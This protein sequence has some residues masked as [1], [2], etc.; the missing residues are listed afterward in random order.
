[1]VAR[2]QYDLGVCELELGEFNEASV[3]LV[4]A[5]AGF[6]QVDRPTEVV[7]TSWSPRRLAVLAG[8]AAEGTRRLD[9]ARADALRLRMSDDAAKITLDLVQALLAAGEVKEIRRLLTQAL[10]H[11]RDAGQ[12]AAVLNAA[13]YLRQAAAAR[14]LTPALI[15]SVRRFIARAERDARLVFVPPS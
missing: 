8:N 1:M 4:A 12:S 2:V 13:A 5:L 3:H 10:R 7:R 6:Q 14:S 11:F 9:A 15:D